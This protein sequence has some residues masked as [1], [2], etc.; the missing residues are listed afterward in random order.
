MYVLY[1]HDNM[2]RRLSLSE[3]LIR[4]IIF[5]SAMLILNY[6]SFLKHGVKSLCLFIHVLA[7]VIGIGTHRT[8]GHLELL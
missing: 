4:I 6:L 5:D 3:T 1:I 7:Y 8:V 2:P